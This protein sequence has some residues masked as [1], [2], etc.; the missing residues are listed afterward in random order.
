MDT[1]AYLTENSGNPPSG[2]KK[3]PLERNV[4]VLTQKEH[5][6][7][8]W[9]GSFWKTQHTRAI[10]R[11]KALIQELQQA[12]AEIICLKQR[13]YGKKSEKTARRDSGVPINRSASS[14]NRGQQ[15]RSKGHGRTARPTEFAGYRRSA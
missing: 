4:V 2:S 10:K 1:V 7:L 12:K 8:K 9:Q 14:R 15:L 11:E 3:T 13:L 5:I 6:E